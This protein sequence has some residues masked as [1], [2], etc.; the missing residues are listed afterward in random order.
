VSIIY[1]M[2]QI[3]VEGRTFEV[4]TNQDGSTFLYE[5]TSNSNLQAVLIE[6]RWNVRGSNGSEYYTPNER[7]SDFLNDICIRA[8]GGV[9]VK[10]EC[11][12]KS[13]VWPT[14]VSRRSR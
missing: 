12:Q 13:A 7:L 4:E 11:L 2:T 9:S 10:L 8:Q 14:L 3:K 5:A 6:G 1:L